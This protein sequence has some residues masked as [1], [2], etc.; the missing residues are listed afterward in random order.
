MNLMGSDSVDGSPVPIR[1]E[2]WTRELQEEDMKA[3]GY[4]ECPG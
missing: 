3:A 1:V 4:K 2:R